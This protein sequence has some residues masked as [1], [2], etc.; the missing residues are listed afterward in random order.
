[1]RGAEFAELKAFV[2]V[3]DRASFAR[4]AD[5][6]G[7]SRSALSQVIRQLESRLGVRLLNRTTRSVSPTEAG[8][9]L[10]ERI[11]PML[12]DMDQAVAEAVGA[13]AR[14]AGT[15]RIN[16]L[17][18][19]AK[20]V[21]APR[22]GRFAQAHPEVVLDIV[23]DDGLADIA[24]EGFDAGI[25]VGGRLQKDMV[26]VRLTP[27]IELLAVA[28]PDYLSRSG[29]PRTPDDLGNHACINWRFPGSGK[30]AGWEFTKRGRRAE[31]VGE[32]PLISNHQDIVVPAA[33]QG[34]GILYAYN[35]DGIAEAL[36]DGRLR[37]VLAD[38]SPTVPG[39]YLYYSSRRYLRPALRA[40]IDC[41]LDRDLNGDDHASPSQPPGV[42]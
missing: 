5:H 21:I 4:A 25:R 3:V 23:I 11:A 31:Y 40:F 36:R 6:L 15:L 41:L 24:G 16:T 28:S 2:A 17:S 20:K 19:A 22:L 7:L 10:H 8:R 9:R 18:M 30:V 42:P 37:R 27:D 29:E 32:G 38:W 12:R 34:L 14:A 35:D 26:A 33:L 39:L 13:N 1:M